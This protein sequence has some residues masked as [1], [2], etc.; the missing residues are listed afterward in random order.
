MYSFHP[1]HTSD[2]VQTVELDID[3]LSPDFYVSTTTS[4][5]GSQYNAF[6][7]SHTPSGE[8]VHPLCQHPTDLFHHNDT[9]PAEEC[10]Q[11]HLP[12]VLAIE[13]TPPNTLPLRRYAWPLAGEQSTLPPQRS[14]SA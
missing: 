6:V 12:H 9:R 5:R 14:T 4:G 11:P 8:R 2:G 13:V 3:M 10:S 7:S 1:L